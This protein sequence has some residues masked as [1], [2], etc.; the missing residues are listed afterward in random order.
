ME[1]VSKVNKNKE[2]THNTCIKKE[3]PSIFRA[4]IANTNTDMDIINL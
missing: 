2:T 4:S 3:Q 1:K